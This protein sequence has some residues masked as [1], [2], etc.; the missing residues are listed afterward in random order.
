[1]ETEKHCVETEKHCVETFEN[2]GC[3]GCQVPFQNK[4][5][6]D[7]LFGVA[8]NLAT[9]CHLLAQRHCIARLYTSVVEDHHMSV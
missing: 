3:L 2:W 1:M 9:G 4:T 8:Q 5:F 7:S 6:E